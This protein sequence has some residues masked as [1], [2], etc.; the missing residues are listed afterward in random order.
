MS[1]QLSTKGGFSRVLGL[2]QGLAADGKRQLHKVTKT[3]RRVA[4][5][6]EY[7]KVRLSSRQA[8]F[9]SHLLS[10]SRDIAY[11][12]RARFALATAKKHYLVFAK[13]YYKLYRGAKRRHKAILQAYKRANKHYKNAL[14]WIKNAIK[15]V[16]RWNPKAAA[17]IQT[18]V[19]GMIKAYF[20]SYS[21]RQSGY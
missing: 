1:T 16:K 13:H 21:I 2:L 4:T 3:W 20:S 18:T 10:A 17:L 9:N 5:L 8:F 11:L 14:K 15:A 12:T 6:C 19:R 7:S